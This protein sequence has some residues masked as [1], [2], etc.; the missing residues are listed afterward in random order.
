MFAVLH[1]LNEPGQ[2]SAL[3]YDGYGYMYARDVKTAR[4]E[5]ERR[6]RT[7][8]A[9]LIELGSIDAATGK[10]LVPVRT[11]PA[12]P[13]TGSVMRLYPIFV[14]EWC[15]GKR[16]SIA[17]PMV[18]A[19]TLTLGA[20]GK[21]TEDRPDYLCNGC[22][23]P[24]RYGARGWSHADD[25]TL[26]RDMCTYLAVNGNRYRSH[27]TTADTVAIGRRV[28]ANRDALRCALHSSY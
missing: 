20:D 24:I 11:V 4:R 12:A 15:D 7:G 17:H 26:I 10:P 19:C 25:R 6:I 9:R 28:R 3:G 18:E 13:Y 2:P 8:S 14:R 27:P 21:I 23:A 16:Y 1:F 5:F 22:Y